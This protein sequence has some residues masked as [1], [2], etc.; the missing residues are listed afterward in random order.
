MTFSTL[1]AFATSLDDCLGVSTLGAGQVATHR[2]E[3]GGGSTF[4]DGGCGAIICCCGGGIGRFLV[5]A[6]AG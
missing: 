2:L 1:G 6:I 4:G 5:T 3:S